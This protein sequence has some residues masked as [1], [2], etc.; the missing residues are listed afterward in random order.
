MY[1]NKIIL[2]KGQ[3]G[4]MYGI[5]L[6]HNDKEGF[7][8]S[9]Q[10]MPRPRLVK[11]YILHSAELQVFHSLWFGLYQ[12]LESVESY[13]KTEH[14]SKLEVL[15]KKPSEWFDPQ[16][17]VTAN[18]LVQIVENRI[19]VMEYDDMVFRVKKEHLPYTIKSN[20]KDFLD[21]PD[22]YLERI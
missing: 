18:D 4:W 1:S 20:Y 22:E 8:K 9:A 19:K 15:V 3:L 13:V 14:R 10:K 21:N 7:G 16:Y 5:T 17:G 6:A 12:R 2:P 11:G